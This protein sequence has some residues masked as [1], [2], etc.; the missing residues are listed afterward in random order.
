MRHLKLLHFFSEDSTSTY[1]TSTRRRTL[2]YADMLHE[3]W[4]YILSIT[5]SRQSVLLDRCN[6]IVG[7]PHRVGPRTREATTAHLFVKFRT[8]IT[9]S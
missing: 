7:R 2:V 9:A 5:N 4:N 6:H 3:R 1:S 8:D